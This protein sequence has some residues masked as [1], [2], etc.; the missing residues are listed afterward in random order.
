MQHNLRIP[1]SEIRRYQ[2]RYDYTADPKLE[3]IRPLA[4]AQGFLSVAQ[5]HE[6]ARWKSKRRAALAQTNSEDFVR[7]ITSFAFTAL[8]EHSRIGSLV[9]L[10]GVQFP[11]ASV[12]LHFC[13]DASYPILD[14]RAIWSLGMEQPSF[15]S[16]EYWV[17]YTSLCRNLAREHD[18]SVRELDMALWQYS[19]EHQNDVQPIGQPDLP[20]SATLSQAGYLKR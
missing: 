18:I 17:N 20:G 2:Q 3:H 13:V 19:K 5:L 10:S 16:P 8:H 6:L 12:I 14:F 4:K 7:E 11:T 15:Y 9:L 1:K